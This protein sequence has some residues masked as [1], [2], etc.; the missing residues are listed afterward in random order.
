SGL[1]RAGSGQDQQRPLAEGDRLALW[2]VQVREQALD[3]VG[4]RLDGRGARIGRGFLRDLH[5]LSSGSHGARIVLAPARSG[6][7]QVRHGA[8]M[9][10]SCDE[11]PLISTCLS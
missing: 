4:A 3:L 2:P 7:D 11:S 6:G 8:K 9:A 1:A 5:F 10:L